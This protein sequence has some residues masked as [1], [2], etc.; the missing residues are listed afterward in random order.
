MQLKSIIISVFLAFKSSHQIMAIDITAYVAQL[1]GE[2]DNN[3]YKASDSLGRIGSEE[4]VKAMIELLN[5]PN[6]ESRFLAARTLGLVDKNDEALAP[7]LEA[8]KSNEN[9]AI[10]GDIM[11]ELEGFDVSSIYVELFKL[12]LFGSF[13]I[14]MVAKDLLDHKEFTITP[15]VLKKFQIHWNH[16]SNNVKQDEVYM[17]R[18]IEV[19]EMLNDLKAFVVGSEEN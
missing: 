7:I 10:A 12:Y 16:Y 19:E 14:S 5:H 2:L 15:R 17:L 3:A 4:V 6:K 8:I 9:S 18:K 1:S 11:I 13:K